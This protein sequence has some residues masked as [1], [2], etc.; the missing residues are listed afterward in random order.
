MTHV[1]IWHS[2]L[3]EYKECYIDRYSSNNGIAFKDK[4]G[5]VLFYID[6][7]DIGVETADLGPE[8]LMRAAP[9]FKAMTEANNRAFQF[10][11][12][13]GDADRLKKIRE[14]LGIR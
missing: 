12:Q 14:A 3:I 10:G 5:V 13:C 2:G 6:G 1:C 8:P 9:I 7:K 4:R 11:M